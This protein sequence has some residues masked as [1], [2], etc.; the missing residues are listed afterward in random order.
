METKCLIDIDIAVG[1]LAVL[2]V[3]FVETMRMGWRTTKTN[4][5]N[6]YSRQSPTGTKI[7]DGRVE[8]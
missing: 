1:I 5:M 2:F 7:E 4:V 8:A 6:L 3:S